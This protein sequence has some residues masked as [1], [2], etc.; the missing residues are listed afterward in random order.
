MAFTNDLDWTGRG[1]E[2]RSVAL[3]FFVVQSDA[4]RDTPD[5]SLGREK[6]RKR[7]KRER[8]QVNLRVCMIIGVDNSIYGWLVGFAGWLVS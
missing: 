1:D 3:P 7:D 8:A 2:E 6:E 5:A 4:L